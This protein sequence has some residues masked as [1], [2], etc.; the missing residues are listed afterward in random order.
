MDEYQIQVSIWCRKE[1]DLMRMAYL[2]RKGGHDAA[3]VKRNHEVKGGKNYPY[4]VFRK[5]TPQE[6]KELEAGII[7]ID[8]NIMMYNKYLKSN[9]TKDG[10]TECICPCCKKPFTKYGCEEDS[11]CHNCKFKAGQDMSGGNGIEWKG[12][13]QRKAASK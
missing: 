6:E 7:T 11:F 4:A 5:L 2:L 10:K 13:K 1:E 9:K 8:H 3:I 12:H